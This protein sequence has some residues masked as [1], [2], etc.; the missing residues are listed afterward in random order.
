MVIRVGSSEGEGVSNVDESR[1]WLWGDNRGIRG[2]IVTKCIKGEAD[3]LRGD[4]ES[5]GAS[6]AVNT[7]AINH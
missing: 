4:G 7:Y 5:V 1:V 2:S 3:G 6:M